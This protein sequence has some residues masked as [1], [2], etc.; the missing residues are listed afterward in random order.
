MTTNKMNP[1]KKKY[2]KPTVKLAKWEL[3]EAI[4]NN[5]VVCLSYTKCLDVQGDSGKTGVETRRDI[6]GEWTRVGSTS[7]NAW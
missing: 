7:R 5:P 3:N 1:K 6:T 4:C 2:A